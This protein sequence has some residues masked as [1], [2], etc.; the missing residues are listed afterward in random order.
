VSQ[1]TIAA[2]AINAKLVD[3]SRE[4]KLIL[5][6]LLSYPI[7]GALDGRRGSYFDF[8]TGTFPAGFVMRVFR[9]YTKAGRKVNLV[10]KPFPTPLG[11]VK[12]VVDAF[13]EDPRYDY[14]SQVMELLCKYGAMIAQVATGGGKSRIAKL[15]FARIQRPTLFLTTRGI[16]MHQMRD[17]FM[18]D[19]NIP[20]GIFG[21]D[22][23]SK[24]H[25]LM[26]CGMVQTFA[27][28]LELKSVENEMRALTE[29]RLTAEDKLVKSITA[30]YEKA[31][32]NGVMSKAV[33]EKECAAAVDREILG[34]RVPYGSD[35]DT[36][37]G[38]QV[39]VHNHNR[40]REET[41]ALLQKFEVLILEEA[42]EASSD[43]YYMVSRACSNAHYRLALTGTPF[44]KDSEQA[45][46]QLEATS[47]A[48]AIRVSELMLIQRGILAKPYFKFLNLPSSADGM[49]VDNDGKEVPAKLYRSTPYARAYEIGITGATQRNIEIVK[50]VQ[51]AITYGLS[52]MVLVQ[53]KVH[54][55]RLVALMTQAG[56]RANFIEG[57]HDQ[58]AR[59]A[60][61]QALKDG[62]IQCLIGSTI[63]DVGVDIPAVGLV[64]LAGAG[65]AEVAVRQRIGRGLRSKSAGPNVCFILDF[66]DPLNNHLKDHARERRRIID[67]TPGFAEGVVSDFPY[68][69]VG[70][71][72]VSG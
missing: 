5:Q 33:A 28:R 65:K 35:E 59:Q 31:V 11:P 7:E 68:E 47:G 60:S 70:Y 40:R 64:V 36:L 49:V 43:S 25:E 2:S 23:W 9:A 37:R 15:C 53:H 10:R 58:N 66:T 32:K 57:E 69:Q 72:K 4:D 19:M 39:K 6:Q 48:V 29:R 52:S 24:A 45:N 12:P 56:I 62:R 30:R 1:I 44:M 71:R 8:D 61:I 16:L 14:Q 67:T 34:A 63:L 18:R 22:E 41:I 20:V 50:E 42:H 51:R 26:N 38:L 21:D 3:P 27:A 46:M 13:P 17:A 55:K 54:G